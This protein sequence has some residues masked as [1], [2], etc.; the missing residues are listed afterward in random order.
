MRASAGTQPGPL[1]KCCI[2]SPPGNFVKP[3]DHTECLKPR[4]DRQKQGQYAGSIG[5][6]GDRAWPPPLE[7]EI[8]KDKQTVNTH[9]SVR[10]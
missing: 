3:N 2:Y 8:F 9:T 6:V 1:N 7:E 5:G 10:P 4:T